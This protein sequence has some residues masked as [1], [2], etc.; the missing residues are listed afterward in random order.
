[1][2]LRIV[3]V[4]ILALLLGACGGGSTATDNDIGTGSADYGQPGDP[5]KATRTVDIKALDTLKYEPASVDVKPGETVT[6]K[7]TNVSKVAHEF[8]IGDSAFQTAHEKE[9]R[10]MPAGMT[11]SDEP[12][13][14][15]LE[16]GE[17][18]SITWTFAKAGALLYACHQPGHYA[19]G[20]KGDI[21]V[22]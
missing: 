4:A 21:K 14:L 1:M 2:K 7:I 9:M 3:A 6:F 11:M 12:A 22:A 20:M 16:P 13:A 8:D 10:S 5:A 17:T 18:K 19:A 15:N